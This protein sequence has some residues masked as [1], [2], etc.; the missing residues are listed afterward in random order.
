MLSRDYRSHKLPPSER[1]SSVPAVQSPGEDSSEGPA[2]PQRRR[3]ITRKRKR[4]ASDDEYE[5]SEDEHEETEDESE[6]E[7]EKEREPGTKVAQVRQRRAAGYD[8]MLEDDGN[9]SSYQVSFI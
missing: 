6:Y 3:Y 1:Q 7:E 8:D 2:S 5:E 9:E 4:A